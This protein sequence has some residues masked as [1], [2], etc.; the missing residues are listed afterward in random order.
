[1]LRTLVHPQII[2]LED[3]FITNTSLYMV[4]ELVKGTVDPETP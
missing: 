2:H 4:M 3:V 1:M